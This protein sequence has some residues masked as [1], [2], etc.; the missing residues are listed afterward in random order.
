MMPWFKWAPGRHALGWLSVVILLAVF[1][2]A[3]AS[4]LLGVP[5]WVALPLNGVGWAA[6]GLAWYARGYNGPLV[7][8]GVF[9]VIW[10]LLELIVIL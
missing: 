5:R 9:V 8:A 7:P 3:I 6:V 10:L 2:A 4:A 1:A